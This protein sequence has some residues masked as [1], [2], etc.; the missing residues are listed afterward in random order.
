MNPG[1]TRYQAVVERRRSNAATTHLD[2]R[3]K[4]NRVKKEARRKAIDD[5]R[6]G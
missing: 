4:R 1:P 6:N 2:K 3:T 5:S